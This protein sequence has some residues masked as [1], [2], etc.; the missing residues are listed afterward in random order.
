M[1]NPGHSFQGCKFQGSRFDFA[2]E[3]RGI[4]RKFRFYAVISTRYGLSAKRY[5]L[6]YENYKINRRPCD[7]RQRNIRA[8]WL[9]NLS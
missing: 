3:K 9:G 4:E 1:E 7:E 8:T 5:Q 2:V 6:R